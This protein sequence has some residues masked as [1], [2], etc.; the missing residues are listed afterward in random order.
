MIK[1]LLPV[2]GAQVPSL[3]R[4]LTRSCKLKKKKSIVC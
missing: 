3:L 2:Q 1:T 4:E